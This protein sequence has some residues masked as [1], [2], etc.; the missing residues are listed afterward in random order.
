MNLA[1]QGREF[2][3]VDAAEVDDDVVRDMIEIL[4]SMLARLFGKRAAVNRAN[5]AGRAV[6]AAGADGEAA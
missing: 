5:R 4:T 3:V 6:N 2:T 1:A